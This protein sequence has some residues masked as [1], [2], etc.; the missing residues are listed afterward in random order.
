M[1][2][3]LVEAKIIRIRAA[4]DGDQDMQTCR[5]WLSRSAIEP[6]RDTIWMPTAG[7]MAVR[8]YRPARTQTLRTSVQAIV[9]SKATLVAYKKI[10]P[11]ACGLGLRSKCSRFLV[12]KMSISLRGPVA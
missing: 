9:G 12:V 1:D 4:P 5:L 7:F 10:C 3:S 6:D 11:E 2:A 8:S